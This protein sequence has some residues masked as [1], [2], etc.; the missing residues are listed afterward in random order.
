MTSSKSILT[1]INGV[2]TNC[3][4]MM[5][6]LI[7]V[8][9]HCV[10]K[11]RAATLPA[12]FAFPAFVGVSAIPINGSIRHSSD[13]NMRGNAILVL[14]GAGRESGVSE[15]DCDRVLECA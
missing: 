2:V 5:T 13:K 12:A 3:K 10:G 4:L 1:A 6:Q 14:L 15:A 8:R 9:V 7:T 11:Y